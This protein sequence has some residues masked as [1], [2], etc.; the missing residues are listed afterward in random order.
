MW[1]F[2][3]TKCIA[4]YVFLATDCKRYE[5]GD[6]KRKNDFEWPYDMVHGPKYMYSVTPHDPGGRVRGVKTLLRGQ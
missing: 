3:N 6:S 2:F 5:H 4:Q 1:N